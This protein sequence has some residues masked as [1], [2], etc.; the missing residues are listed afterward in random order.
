MNIAT[1]RLTTPDRLSIVDNNSDFAAVTGHFTS[2]QLWASTKLF[3]VLAVLLPAVLVAAMPARAQSSSLYGA[4]GP[5]RRLTLENSSWTHVEVQAPGEEIQLHDVVTVIV[6]EATE[7]VSEGQINRRTQSNIDARLRDWLKLDGLSLT[8]APLDNG[9]PRARGTLD[10]QLRTQM[11]LDNRDALQF[12]IAA[13]VVDIR[14]NG[15]LVIEAHK[16]VKNNDEEM[17]QSLS[18]LVR[19]EDVLPNNTVLSEDVAELDIYKREAGH[20]RDASR[21][22]WFLKALDTMKPF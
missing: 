1:N 4:A 21:R 10:S 14:P 2:S 3:F 7:Y 6:K 20:V 8:P 5:Q 12:R 19:R 16:R 17:E 11:Q 22:G 13:E 15:L 18:G 9:E